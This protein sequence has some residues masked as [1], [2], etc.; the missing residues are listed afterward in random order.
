M[1]Q[2]L[3]PAFP[4]VVQ[5]AYGSLSPDD[6]DKI[7]TMLQQNDRICEIDLDL[8]HPLSEKESRI[9]QEPFPLLECLTLCS[10]Q[11]GYPVLPN[12]FLNGSAPR[13]SALRLYG[14]DFPA[15]P[16]FLSS[17]SDLVDLLLHRIPSNGSLSSEALARGLS[18]APR[19]KTLSLKITPATT[20][21]SPR[22]T[23]PS[24]PGHI[25]LPALIN[26]TLEGPC[27]YLEDFLSRIS[28]PALERAKIQFVVDRPSFDVS[29]LS[30]FLSRVESQRSPDAAQVILSLPDTFVYLSPSGA[31]AQSASLPNTSSEWLSLDLTFQAPFELFQ[32]NQICQQ[33]SP[34]LSGVRALDV[35]TANC[36]LDNNL[37]WDIF[38]SFSSVERLHVSGLSTSKIASALQFD[39]AIMAAD[40][41]PGLRELILKPGMDDLTSFSLRYEW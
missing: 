12:T 8:Y 5:Y 28:A 1:T 32:M 9:M 2:D 10:W 29:R 11:G 31:E 19:L 16:L 21:P 36:Q 41:L 38:N 14:I 26:L 22:T 34:F 6:R 20:H 35:H 18:A 4:I 37:L 33:L 40:V 30:Q 25:I 24:S 27:D 17:A 13:L 15:L 3:W 7:A 39:S 23:P